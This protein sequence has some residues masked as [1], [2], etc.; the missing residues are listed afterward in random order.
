MAEKHVTLATRERAKAKGARK[1]P[2]KPEESTKKPKKKPAKRRT[3]RYAASSPSRTTQPV[4]L[5]LP[6]RLAC[7]VMLDKDK[8]NKV[9]RLMAYTAICRIILHI[10]TRHNRS[11]PHARRNA[12]DFLAY[13]QLWECEHTNHPRAQVNPDTAVLAGHW[14]NNKPGFIK[15]CLAD[16]RTFGPPGRKLARNLTAFMKSS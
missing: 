15:A 3:A 12:K 8:L 9:S 10:S 11:W 7:L 5:S 16:L 2:Q 14:C 4:R 13:F 6:A 1:G